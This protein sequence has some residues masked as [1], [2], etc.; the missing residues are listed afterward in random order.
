MHVCGHV[1]E[2]YVLDESACVHTQKPV[3]RVWYSSR[4]SG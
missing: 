2:V 3:E 4:V 1:C